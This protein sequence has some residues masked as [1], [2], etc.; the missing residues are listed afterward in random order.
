MK[1]YNRSL[2][3]LTLALSQAKLGNAVTAAKMLV[4]ASQ[5][6]DSEKALAILEASN[7]QAFDIQAKAIA[8][9]KVVKASALLATAAATRLKA[10]EE[11]L[12]DLII[13]DEE[14]VAGDEDKAMDK[15]AEK[16]EEAE[17]DEHEVEE[18][19]M[20]EA[21]ASVLASL[22]NK[23]KVTKARK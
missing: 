9:A 4:K 13:D 12:S 10:T 8:A 15:K 22:I 1:V 11:D 18:E 7:A 16:E 5:A 21:V 17:D 14:D 19:D 20:S 6:S 2:D 23:A 3:L